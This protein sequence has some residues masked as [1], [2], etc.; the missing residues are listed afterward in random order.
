MLPW[1]IA[2]LRPLLALSVHCTRL[3]YTRLLLYTD[4]HTIPELPTTGSKKIH[5]FPQKFPDIRDAAV[6]NFSESAS[7]WDVIS[8]RVLYG[9][10]LGAARQIVR[11]RDSKI[12]AS[13]TWL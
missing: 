13:V 8:V 10:V 12:L 11:A 6:Y 2:T 4:G 3:Q 5:D 7:R 9:V 1:P